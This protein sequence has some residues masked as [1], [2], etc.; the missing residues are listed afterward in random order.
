MIAVL[1]LVLLRAP[2]VVAE[3]VRTA[4]ANHLAN[5][6]PAKPE[7]TTTSDSEGPAAVES[8]TDD[9][10]TPVS[11][12]PGDAAAGPDGAT[13]AP[14]TVVSRQG[15]LVFGRRAH[16]NVSVESRMQV[17]LPAQNPSVHLSAAPYR[18][19]SFELRGGIDGLFSLHRLA[20]ETDG[21]SWFGSSGPA[22]TRSVGASDV[23][24]AAAL[25]MIGL[26]FLRVGGP[27]WWE[28]I[29]RYE[30]SSYATTATPSRSVCL[31]S[32]DADTSVDP[33]ACTRTDAPLK[34]ASRFESFVVGAQFGRPDGP[35]FA[36]VGVD[37]VRQR[38]PYQVNVDG[39]TLDDL[40]FDARFGGAGLAMGFGVGREEGLSF[41]GGL[42]FG[43]AWVS[44]SDD[45]SLGSVVPAG[46]DL[47]YFRWDTTL[48]YGLLLWRGPP[49][50]HLRA[51]VDAS[52]SHF[53]YR[54]DG[55]E[56]TPSL[57]RDIFFGGRLALVLML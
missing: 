11:D 17:W 25:I 24:A 42:H 49:L 37:L 55:R 26:P 33:P 38:K 21:S 56:E 28:P 44:L 35:A 13:A 10:S 43:T 14:S 18:T 8:A 19:W 36:H 52:G 51:A 30:V 39:R 32:R 47:E 45:L 29:V 54:Q 50:L 27:T 20:L 7:A 16:L 23:S 53:L 48:S 9:E 46:W 12:A 4:V 57:S 41:R 34:M 31:V 6:L 22:V 3:S 1:G 5:E 2:A 40:L 15:P